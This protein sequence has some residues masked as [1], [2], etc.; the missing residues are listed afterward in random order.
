MPA[1]AKNPGLLG[2]KTPTTTTTTTTPVR[3][4]TTVTTTTTATPKKRKPK[5]ELQKLLLSSP[6]D[7]D[8]NRTF[9]AKLRKAAADDYYEYIARD[10]KGVKNLPKDVFV[11][12][13]QQYFGAKETGNYYKGAAPPWKALQE[14]DD[15]VFR[16]MPKPVAGDNGRVTKSFLNSNKPVSPSSSTPIEKK[17][18]P[19][20]SPG[21]TA[22][23]DLPET[24]EPPTRDTTTGYP[25]ISTG[26]YSGK[27]LPPA[28][29]PTAST[30][31]G[32]GSST[33]SARDH[34]WGGTPIENPIF[35]TV[36]GK[37]RRKGDRGE[38]DTKGG[39]G[40]EEYMIEAAHEQTNTLHA[41]DDGIYRGRRE[42]ATN[43]MATQAAI[44]QTNQALGKLVEQGNELGKN[45][46]RTASAFGQWTN[47][48]GTEGDTTEPQ[49][50]G[51][52]AEGKNVS[53][54][55][56]IVGEGSDALTLPSADRGTDSL[57]PQFGIGGSTDMVPTVKDQL[58]SDLEFDMF[59]TVQP[60]YG[61]GVDN[62]LFLY[63][64]RRDANI[65]YREPQYDHPRQW[66]G[67]TDSPYPM[68]WQ[69]QS[70]IDKGDLAQYV[71]T[72]RT[73]LGMSLDAQRQYDRKSNN[74]LGDD[75]GYPF[76]VTTKGLAHPPGSVLEPIVNN[77]SPWRPVKPPLGKDLN[78]QQFRRAFD[79]LRQ[80]DH[81][82]TNIAQEGGPTLRKRRA[83]EVIL[84]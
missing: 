76:R 21:S 6:R 12:S 2:G 3:T 13:M 47:V 42:A 32:T 82:S 5:T 14:F 71:N 77:V 74:I 33:G 4:T 80:P 83:L 67:P 55:D 25:S 23:P 52:D 46:Q 68:P 40:E 15:E 70:V 41:I 9:Q 56:R 51:R 53:G 26:G 39:D 57:R 34:V 20:T 8:T 7:A 44:E 64:Q 17:L 78:R 65:I 84:Q 19:S 37:K 66:I 35:G 48:T 63:E 22:L 11:A 60:G 28:T 49:V 72:E 29:G 16:G 54:P 61:E 45:Q 31:S 58:R 27:Y 43:A 24:P 18:P 62:K 69:W 59:N 36:T 10:Y 50:L 30:G 38:E 79:A 73:K 75:H 1:K 81:F